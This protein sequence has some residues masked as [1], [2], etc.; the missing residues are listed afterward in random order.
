MQNYFLYLES[1]LYCKLLGYK[2]ML[3]IYKITLVMDPRSLENDVA[4]LHTNKSK[5]VLFLS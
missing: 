2:I 3:L 4:F 1:G 5:L